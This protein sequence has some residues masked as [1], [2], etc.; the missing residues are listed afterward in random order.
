MTYTACSP[1]SLFD[2]QCTPSPVHQ[3]REGYALDNA[4]LSGDEEEEDNEGLG[5][6]IEEGGHLDKEEGDYDQEE[7]SAAIE[8][9]ARDEYEEEI[10]I[11][12]DF[13]DTYRT[14]V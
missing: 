13:S 7:L 5:D 14:S 4:R 1:R 10:H 9:A 2:R 3:A 8:E 11:L 12:D 6:V